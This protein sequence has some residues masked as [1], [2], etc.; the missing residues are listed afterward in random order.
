MSAFA[1]DQERNN[2]L[3]KYLTKIMI[4]SPNNEGARLAWPGGCENKIIH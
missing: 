4:N 1:G 3:E 2:K